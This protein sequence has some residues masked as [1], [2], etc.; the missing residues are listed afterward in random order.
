MEGVGSRDRMEDLGTRGG[1]CGSCSAEA[2]SVPASC[3]ILY[4][5]R[6]ISGRD[7]IIIFPAH[8]T[9]LSWSAGE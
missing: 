4:F 9:A 2:P 7:L 8:N 3:V 1:G 6:A 5:Q